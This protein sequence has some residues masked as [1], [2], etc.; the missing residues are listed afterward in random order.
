MRFNPPPWVTGDIL[1]HAIGVLK[2]FPIH[3]TEIRS[4]FNDSLTV[5]YI[6]QASKKAVNE[7]IEKMN[8]M[9]T[10]K[11]ALNCLRVSLN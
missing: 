6:T 3:S 5:F 7:I 1:H 2:V 11:F 9:T 4:F 10:N 8:L